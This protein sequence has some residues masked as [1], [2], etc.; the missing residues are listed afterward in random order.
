MDETSAVCCRSCAVRF[1]AEKLLNSIDEN[2]LFL[3]YCESDCKIIGRCQ[4]QPNTRNHVL[5]FSRLDDTIGHTIRKYDMVYYHRHEVNS[6]RFY[7][8]DIL[9]LASSETIDDGQPMPPLY[10]SSDHFDFTSDLKRVGIDHIVLNQFNYAKELE[11]MIRHIS[12]D[13]PRP[14][15]RFRIDAFSLP[16]AL[17]VISNWLTSLSWFV[18]ALSSV[19]SPSQILA[20]DTFATGPLRL[21]SF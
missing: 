17:S 5:S 19:L 12:I 15:S 1:G 18:P 21:V 6:M 11:D 20:K 10:S 2:T 3:K 7:S 16:F 8:F 14:R 4:F 13:R 9:G